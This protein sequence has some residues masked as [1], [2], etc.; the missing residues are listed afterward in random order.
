LVNCKGEVDFGPDLSVDQ[1]KV[2]SL[3]REVFG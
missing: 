2:E 1:M 3:V